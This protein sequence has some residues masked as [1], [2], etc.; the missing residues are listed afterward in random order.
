[1][2]RLFPL[3]DFIEKKVRAMLTIQGC[4][5][6]L[7]HGLCHHWVFAVLF[8]LAVGWTPALAQDGK[9][10]EAQFRRFVNQHCA[11]CHGPD[12]QKRKLRLDN[13]AV[14]FQD[15]DAAA[16]WE[17]ILDRL[18]AA[19]CRPRAGRAR[20]RRNARGGRRPGHGNC[21]TPRSP[22]NSA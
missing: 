6:R 12:V 4:A 3:A 17:K 19:R 7:W 21:T 5:V 8:L 14:K 22:A 9:P 13:L 10:F 1:M 11:S 2:P 20:R 15:K 16:T 18:A